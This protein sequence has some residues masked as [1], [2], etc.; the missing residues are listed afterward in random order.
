[1][2]EE[3]KER[4]SIGRFFHKRVAD[5]VIAV[6]ALFVSA[7][8]LWV[9]IRTE[10]AN[11]KMVS[12][13]TWPFLQVQIS[14]ATT[15]A[16]PD[17]QFQVINAGVGPAMIESFELFWKGKPYRSARQLLADCYGFRD[18]LATSAAAKSHTPLLTGTVQGIVL[19]AGETRDVHP[20]SAWK[21]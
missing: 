9:G 21:R 18:V 6:V 16:K 2:A 3:N 7:I 14:N 11:E 12:A 10:N 15:D 13:S 5:I 1:M 17:L 20:L 19:R 4:G 8:S